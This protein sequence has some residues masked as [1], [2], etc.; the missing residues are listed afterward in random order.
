MCMRVYI[1]IE[2]TYIHLFNL[3]FFLILYYLYIAIGFNTTLS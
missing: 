1:Y 3:A 2:F